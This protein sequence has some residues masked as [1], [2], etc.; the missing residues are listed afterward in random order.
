MEQ[1]RDYLIGE[2]QEEKEASNTTLLTQKFTQAEWQEYFPSEDRTIYVIT[3]CNPNV[4]YGKVVKA[5]ECVFDAVCEC[6]KLNRRSLLK[7]Q[8]DS[9]YKVEKCTLHKGE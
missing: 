1:I 3:R 9:I 2:E 7:K 8:Y 5:Y 4:T 6:N